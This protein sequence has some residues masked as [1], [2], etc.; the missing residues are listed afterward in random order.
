[1]SGGKGE[2]KDRKSIQSELQWVKKMFQKKVRVKN[3]KPYEENQI[4]Y[5]HIYNNFILKTK[6]GMLFH[7]EYMACKMFYNGKKKSTPM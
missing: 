6:T 5:T 7:L 3:L 4:I 1:M 2:K